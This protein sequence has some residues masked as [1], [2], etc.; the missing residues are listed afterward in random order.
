VETGKYKEK[1]EVGTL[2]L[3]GR[4]VSSFRNSHIGFVTHHNVKRGSRVLLGRLLTSRG[5]SD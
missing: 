2:S 5:I 1:R 3:P 4:R